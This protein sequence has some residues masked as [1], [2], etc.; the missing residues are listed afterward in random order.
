VRRANLLPRLL[1]GAV[2]LGALSG[3]LAACSGDDSAL[4]PTTTTVPEDPAV[5]ARERMCGFFEQ[6]VAAENRR[7][8]VAVEDATVVNRLEQAR[9]QALQGLLVSLTP[10]VPT[11]VKDALGQLKGLAIVAG[12][13]PTTPPPSVDTATPLLVVTTSLNPVCGTQATTTTAAAGATVAPPT[14]KGS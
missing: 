4:I 1:L 5:L 11:G 2:S 14:T 3:G 10:D 13:D 9:A 8:S 6:Y 12:P 7:V